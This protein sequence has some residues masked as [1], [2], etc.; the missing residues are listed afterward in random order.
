MRRAGHCAGLVLADR[1]FETLTV[2]REIEGVAPVAGIL[3][4]PY[5]KPAWRQRG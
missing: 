5:V 4:L 1:P 3:D 2:P